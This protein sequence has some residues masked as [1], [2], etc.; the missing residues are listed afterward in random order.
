MLRTKAGCQFCLVS[1]EQEFKTNCDANSLFSNGCFWDSFVP[2][3]YEKEWHLTHCK[4]AAL[5]AVNGIFFNTF[6][7][8]IALIVK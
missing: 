1:C 2:W 8:G 4:I 3:Q 6:D 7:S 5:F